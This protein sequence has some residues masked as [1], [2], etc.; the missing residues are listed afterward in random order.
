MPSVLIS[1]ND[2][3]TK[4]SAKPPNVTPSLSRGRQKRFM[5]RESF[6]PLRSRRRL[7]FSSLSRNPEVFF[8]FFFATPEPSLQLPRLSLSLTQRRRCLRDRHDTLYQV[9]IEFG[10]LL[11]GLPSFLP[12]FG[13]PLTVSAK[14]QRMKI[15]GGGGGE[16]A[17]KQSSAPSDRGYPLLRTP[18]LAPRLRRVPEHLA[19]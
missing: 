12:S 13:S 3:R 11:L 16:R 15:G 10:P 7:H 17:L 5:R 2:A 8:F 9:D 6:I 14:G 19:R 18:L 1:R 4:V